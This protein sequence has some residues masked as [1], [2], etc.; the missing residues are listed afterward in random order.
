MTLDDEECYKLFL[1]CDDLARIRRGED[2]MV[3]EMREKLLPVYRAWHQA[4][5]FRVHR[6]ALRS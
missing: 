1:I 3:N 5:P 6:T 2:S 4:N